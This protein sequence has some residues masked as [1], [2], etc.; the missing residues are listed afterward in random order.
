MLL[1]CVILWIL[2]RRSRELATVCTCFADVELIRVESTNDYQH[3]ALT[4]WQAEQL[5]RAAR[6]NFWSQVTLL[7]PCCSYLT[8]SLAS[9]FGVER[10][11]WLTQLPGE[12][13]AWELRYASVVTRAK[14]RRQQ[15]RQ[16]EV[17]A[18]ST[19]STCVESLSSTHQRETHK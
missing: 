6:R 12:E 7:L 11:S 15:Q 19:S 5:L 10:R 16:N 3:A 9:Y 14:R 2:Y 4:D 8:F 18:A 17:S 13:V 1:M